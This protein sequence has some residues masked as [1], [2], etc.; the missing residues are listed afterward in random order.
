MRSLKHNNT[1]Y[2]HIYIKSFIYINRVIG[3]M[4]DLDCVR[5]YTIYD[6]YIQYLGLFKD[7]RKATC[8]SSNYETK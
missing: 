8:V 7:T 2:I 4:T 1:R 3:T 6:Y 5:A